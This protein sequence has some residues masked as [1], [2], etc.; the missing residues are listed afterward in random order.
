MQ[1]KGGC[2]E[3]SFPFLLGLEE[4]LFALEDDP[5][6]DAVFVFLVGLF[7]EAEGLWDHAGGIGEGVVVDLDVEVFD[8]VGEAGG[9]FGG[10]ELALF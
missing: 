1:G 9:V 8:E 7:F 5:A 2:V 3:E 6:F 10:H 4:V